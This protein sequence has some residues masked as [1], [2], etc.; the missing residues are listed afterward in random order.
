[1]SDKCDFLYGDDDED[2]RKDAE[3]QIKKA[4]GKPVIAETFDEYVEGWHS[5]LAGAAIDDYFTGENKSGAKF[6]AELAED[7]DIQCHLMLLSGNTDINT[8]KADYSEGI[9][10]TYFRIF[11]KECFRDGRFYA[12]VKF[13]LK[14]ESPV[15]EQL[16][17][18]DEI[19]EQNNMKNKSASIINDP[20]DVTIPEEEE[21]SSMF[22]Q[23]TL[24]GLCNPKIYDNLATKS[25][26]AKRL[27]NFLTTDTKI[28]LNENIT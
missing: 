18:I 6:L 3:T 22:S 10:K 28:Q 12:A 23:S 21:F 14:C 20:L 16:R 17:T 27:W 13:C 1:M 26:F 2:D 5:D 15:D 9:G 4:G 7:G 24:G 25:L 19:L 11:D 8:L